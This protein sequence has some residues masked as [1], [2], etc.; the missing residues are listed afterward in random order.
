MELSGAWVTFQMARDLLSF[1]LF[2]PLM[3][4]NH[5]GI[6]LQVI[7]GTIRLN[8]KELKKS[9]TLLLKQSRWFADICFINNSK[10]FPWV[11]FKP[12][13]SRARS[14]KRRCCSKATC[15]L[16]RLSRLNPFPLLIWCVAK[17]ILESIIPRNRQYGK[18]MLRRQPI[19]RFIWATITNGHYLDKLHLPQQVSFSKK[20]RGIQSHLQK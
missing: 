17:W 1:T 18:G 4:L 16:K 8:F 12:V 2:F 6:H 13:S 19:I 3:I 20:W 9:A 7:P 5:S 14:Q 11:I 10:A 15:E